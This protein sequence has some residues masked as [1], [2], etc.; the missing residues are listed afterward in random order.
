QVL[1]QALGQVWQ[2]GMAI[3]WPAYHAHERCRRIPLPTYPFERQRH[4]IERIGVGELPITAAQPSGDGLY[5][6]VWKQL[7]PLSEERDAAGSLWLVLCDAQGIGASLRERLMKQDA[8]TIIITAGEGYRRIDAEHYVIDAAAEADY[9]RVLHEL[10][11]PASRSIRV[12]HLWSFDAPS[13]FDSLLYLAR[14]LAAACA[15]SPATIDLVTDSALSITGEEPI[16]ASMALGTGLCKVIP[17]ELPQCRCYHIDV[18]RSAGNARL[19][20]QLGMEITATER[21]MQVAWRGSRRW[22]LSYERH[23]SAAGALRIK[24]HGHYL[25]TG[26]L[27]RIGLALAAH[28]AAGGAT[29]ITLIARKPPAED[30]NEYLRS[31]EA[32]GCKLLCL[33]ADV[34]DYAQMHAAFDRAEQE[35]GP[36]DTVIHGAGKVRDAMQGLHELAGSAQQEH[37][38]AKVHGTQVLARCIDERNIGLCLLMSSLSAVLGGLGL[39]AYAAANSYLDAFAQARH[40]SGDRRWLSVNWD[41][42]LFEETVGL[43]S[44]H[45]G[46]TAA[47]GVRIFDRLMRLPSLPQWVHSAQ[48]LDARIAQWLQMTPARKNRAALHARPS[49]PTDYV[50][51]FGATEQKLVV[52]WQDVLGIGQIGTRDNFFELGGDSLTL[53]QVHKS[54]RAQGYPQ[55]TIANLFQFPTIAE[56][57]HFLDAAQQGAS[58]AGIVSKR[59]ERRRNRE[60]AVDTSS[61]ASQP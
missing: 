15:D 54:I 27:G 4:W 16:D 36:I 10:A 38:R 59:L 53:V 48:A 8:D 51:P 34:A 26:G 5:A 20:V 2:A 56:L 43:A 40:N 47:E 50:E 14:S 57:A 12:V 52:V 61:T 42:W 7:A 11:V 22:G 28:L 9:A 55:I 3:D 33:V 31:I 17:Q 30:L 46:V 25:I 21:P 19:A 60:L 6:P 23:S 1:Q 29:G 37:F 44:S 58:A 13:N 24:T 32:S 45:P 35:V 49:V 18:Q 39:G 41:G